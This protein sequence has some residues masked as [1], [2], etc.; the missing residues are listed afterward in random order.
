MN[1]GFIQTQSNI[2]PPFPSSSC[3]TPI[4]DRKQQMTGAY[5]VMVTSTFCIQYIYY[6]L[7]LGNGRFVHL[8]T[9]FNLVQAH[10]FNKPSIIVSFDFF[11][12][13]PNSK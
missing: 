1:L 6:G 7:I 5:F 9:Q 3:F 12:K 4:T 11:E 10:Q 2:Y 8:E 13:K